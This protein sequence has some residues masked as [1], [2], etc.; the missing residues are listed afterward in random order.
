MNDSTPSW[1]LEPS[2]EEMQQLAERAVRR[3]LDHLA[4]LPQQPASD[5]SDALA[6]SRSLIEGIPWTPGDV[7]AI[8]DLLFET[9]VPKSFNAA[10]PGYLAYIPGGGIYAAAVADFVADAVNRYTGVF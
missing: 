10:G 1:P 7:E 5:V 3:V 8:F 2:R 6:L 9:A 4:S